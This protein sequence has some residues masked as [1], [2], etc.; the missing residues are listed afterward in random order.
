MKLYIKQ[1]P[2]SWR[3]RFFIKDEYGNDRYYAEGELFS[4]G[5]KLH[6]YLAQEGYEIA[7]IRQKV[8]SFRPRYF[9]EINGQTFPIVREFTFFRPRFY[10]EG[11]DWA[12]EGDFLRHEYTMGDRGGLIMRMSKHWFTWGDS[13]ELEIFDP[14]NELLCLTVALA[15][16]CMNAD[17][18]NSS[19]GHH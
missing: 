12:M 18:S 8:W 5:R 11:V 1:K 16:D 14:R 10:L 13:Y 4:W 2:F 15:I 9:I 19:G 3:D 6:V 17:A 7:F